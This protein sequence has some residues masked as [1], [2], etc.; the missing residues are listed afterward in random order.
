VA[1]TAGGHAEVV[2][3][4]LGWPSAGVGTVGSACRSPLVSS[5]REGLVRELVSLELSHWVGGGW[6]LP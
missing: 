3:V 5:W 6:A 2:A 4:T 1:A